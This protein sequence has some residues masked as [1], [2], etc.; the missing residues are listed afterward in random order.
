MKLRSSR[1]FSGING[2]ELLSDGI[3]H[4]DA[5]I[6]TYNEQAKPFAWSK[7]QV[8]QKRLKP[9]SRNSDS[10]TSPVLGG[11]PAD[12]GRLIA[13]ETEKWPMV[14]KFTGDKPG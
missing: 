3:W 6:Q 1:A 7:S 10:G 2:L 13:E 5:F 12:F 14:V 4:L 8:H 11:S 9:R